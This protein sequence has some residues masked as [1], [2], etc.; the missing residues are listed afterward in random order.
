MK[1]F[2]VPPGARNVVALG[3]AIGVA[4]SMLT[5]AAGA[6]LA[7]APKPQKLANPLNDLLDEARRDIDANRFEA[8]V[9]PLQKVIAE[10]PDFAYAHFQLAY[11]YTALK[12]DDEARAEYQRTIALDPKMAEAHLNLGI[13]LLA[14]DPAAAVTSLRK[15]VE[16]LPSQS[17]PRFF[18]GLAQERSGDAKSAAE[19]YQE[20]LRLDS[21]DEEALTRLASLYLSMSRPADAEQKFRALLEVKPNDP[22]ALL[23]LAR[24]LDAQKKPGAAEI[25]AKYSALRPDD[26]GVQDR[27]IH[28]LMDQK[29]YDAA[30][31]ELDRRDAARQPSLESLKLRA[32]ILIAQKNWPNSIAV[33]R[34]AIALAPNDP[35]LHA[36]LGRIYLETRDFPNAE[37]EIKTAIRLDGKNMLY[38]KDLGTTYYLS[39]NYAAT[40]A[41]LDQIDRVEPPGPG[42]W[43][44]RA[45]CYDNLK[46]VKPAF[47]AYQKFLDLDGTKNPDQVWQA[48]QRSKVLKRE[49]GQKR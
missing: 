34:R 14:K 38:W 5:I 20:A 1:L 47:E 8:A 31:A 24:S 37:A 17:R 27:S 23:G 7:Q 13:L 36:G 16:L 3:I 4:G 46:Q 21:R 35:Q 9:A 26:P 18:L 41:V 30:L 48:Q 25:Y 45:L 6:A 40:L 32:D 44:I 49:L 15:A 10:Q 12:K 22:A 19:S 42:S 43:F 39:K 28:L 29:Q 11:V 33:L 2:R